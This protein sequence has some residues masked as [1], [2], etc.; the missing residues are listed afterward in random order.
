MINGCYAPPPDKDGLP[1][2][3]SG[4]EIYSAL[5][6]NRGGNKFYNNEVRHHLATGMAVQGSNGTYITGI[7]RYSGDALLSVRNNGYYDNGG[8]PP[9]IGV[10]G[11]LFQSGG[12]IGNSGISLVH[13]RSQNNSGDALHLEPSSSGTGFID[14]PRMPGSCLVLLC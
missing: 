1:Q 2:Y 14:D 3:A 6:D 7:P 8:Q 9:R 5:G 13:L 10:H 12:G 4:M 11:I